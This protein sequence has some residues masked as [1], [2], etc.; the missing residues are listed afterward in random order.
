MNTALL[1][2]QAATSTSLAAQTLPRK[3]FIEALASAIEGHGVKNLGGIERIE[4]MRQEDVAE[5][6]IAGTVFDVIATEARLLGKTVDN[7]VGGVMEVLGFE[8]GSA[9]AADQAHEIGCYCHGEFIS[10]IMAAGRVRNLVNV[11]E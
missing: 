1:E 3:A 11:I 9:F 5:L 6:P 8:R 2:R 4:D 10:S 7:T